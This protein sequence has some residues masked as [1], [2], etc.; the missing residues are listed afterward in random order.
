MLRKNIMKYEQGAVKNNRM[1]W[2]RW[3]GK[4]SVK[5]TLKKRLKFKN[6]P[7]QKMP[8]FD[9]SDWIIQKAMALI[10]CL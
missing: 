7:C 5:F 3:S 4:V 10:G 8:K 9:L 2:P 1:F 6:E